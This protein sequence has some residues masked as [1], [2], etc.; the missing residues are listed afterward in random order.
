MHI[1]LIDDDAELAAMLTE[2]LGAEG[3][4]TTVALNGEAGLEAALAGP[5][6]AVVLDVMMPRLGGIEVLRRL[7]EK[8]RVPVI[9][10][11]AKGDNIERVIGLEMGADDYIPKP[12]YPRELVARLRAVL[13]RTGGATPAD[14]TLRL[15]ALNLSPGRH[16]ATWAGRAL[17][18]TASEFTLLE[19]LLAAGE[20]VSTKD[21]LSEKAL[22]R[23]R[24]PYDRSV[25]VHMSNL[26]QKLAAA[27]GD[28][29]HI[30][31]VRGIGYRLGRG[32]AA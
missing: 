16:E 22:G 4:A 3:F 8:S 28:A 1:L 5:Y 24:Q 17:D 21:E 25:D 31:T 23:K 15:D 18:L 13:R 7:R 26:R 30:E 19:V 27:A 32:A 20:R 2:Y 14:D 29:L 6:D 11:T 9:M 12:C 10:L